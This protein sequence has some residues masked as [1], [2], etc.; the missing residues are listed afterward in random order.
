MTV[1]ASSDRTARTTASVLL[2]VERVT[3]HGVFQLLKFKR[4]EEETETTLC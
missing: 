4:A 3:T 1:T 2:T